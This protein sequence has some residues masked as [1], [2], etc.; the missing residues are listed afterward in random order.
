MMRNTAFVLAAALLAACSSQSVD[1]AARSVESEAPALFQDGLTH[2]SLRAKIAAIDIDAATSVG[3]AVHGGHVTLT[4]DVR[5]AQERA[6][7]VRAAKSIKGVTSVDDELGVD[8]QMRGTAQRA[9]DF[10]L[11]TRV[12][13]ELAAQTG[14][15]AINVE[16]S[17]KGGVVTLRGDVPTS[18]IKSTM[19]NAARRTSGVRKVVDAIKVKP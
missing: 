2:A 1:Q 8:P 16:A 6:E 10:A 4:G 13:G 17:A 14:I 19:L 7:L 3:I 9:G 12:K 5:S 18:A 15:N 11:A